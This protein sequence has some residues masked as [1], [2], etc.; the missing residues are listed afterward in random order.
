[1][2]NNLHD[3]RNKDQH[4]RDLKKDLP[5]VSSSHN[6][7]NKNHDHTD[8]TKKQ[9]LIRSSIARLFRINAEPTHN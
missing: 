8:D 7:S 5:H 3:D 4:D 2:L 9:F 1:M 6:S